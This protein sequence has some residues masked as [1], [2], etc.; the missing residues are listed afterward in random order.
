MKKITIFCLLL[1][2]ICIPKFVDAK[3]LNDYYNELAK[4]QK[5]YNEKYLYTLRPASAG[6]ERGSACC[7]S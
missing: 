4:L 1:L 2:V 7:I 3:T 6:A 5:E